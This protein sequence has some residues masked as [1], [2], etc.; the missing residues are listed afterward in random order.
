MEYRRYIPIAVLALAAVVFQ[1]IVSAI[2][3]EY[4]LTQLTMSAYYTVVILGLAVLMGYAGQISIGHAAFFAIGGY[5]TAVLTSRN[6]AEWPDWFASL[7][8]FLGLEAVSKNAYG[9]EVHHLSPWAALAIAIALTVAVALV[10]GIP[11]LKLKGHYLAMA[12]LGFGIIIHRI[13]LGSPLF[14]EADG[15][16][17]IPPFRLGGGLAV[18]GDPALRVQNFYIA[19]V[20]VILGTIIL[21]NLVD[22]RIGRALRAIHGNEEA[23][24]AMGVPTGRYKLIVFVLSAVYAC[25]A[26]VFLTHFN[27]GIGPSEAE[28]MKSVNYLAIVAVGGM[29][30]IWGSLAMGMI[31]NYLSLR[32]YFGS[33]DE[34]VFGG[35]LIVI[36]MF[37]PQGLLRVEHVR[38]LGRVATR[39]IRMGKVR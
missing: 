26:G 39:L 3:R 23:A 29:A 14:G 31:L 15:I 32:G 20:I 24:S 10:V 9:Q 35:I 33:F 22:S 13:V 21:L 4:Y 6:I 7:M 8:R 38:A 25:I 28:V 17:D 2:D 1:L 27:G 37:F 30:N 36:M 34:F 19:A 12:T 16:S 5:T 11:I 18:C